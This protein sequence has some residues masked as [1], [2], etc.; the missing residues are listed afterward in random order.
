MTLWDQ[1][2][3]RTWSQRAGRDRPAPAQFTTARADASA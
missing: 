3:G 2:G 1:L